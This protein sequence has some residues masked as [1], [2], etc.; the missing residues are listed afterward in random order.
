M[1]VRSITLDAFS[2]TSFDLALRQDGFG[3]HP[4]YRCLV[5][6]SIRL[7]IFDINLY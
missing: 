3:E 7:D 4:L 5:A 6:E 1:K 2:L